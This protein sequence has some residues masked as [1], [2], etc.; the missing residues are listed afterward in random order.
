MFLINSFLI[1]DASYSIVTFTNYAIKK[2]NIT[3]LTLVT[4]AVKK[5]ARGR[6]DLANQQ[7][8]YELEILSCFLWPRDLFIYL[9][10]RLVKR[11]L[12]T[13]IAAKLRQL[14][15]AKSKKEK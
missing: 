3:L 5:G 13:R 4:E 1:L 7:S 11:L 15:N 10:E 2:S 9:K 8:K 6:K 14:K 12:A